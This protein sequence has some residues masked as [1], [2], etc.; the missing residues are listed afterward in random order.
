[1]IRCSRPGNDYVY[2]S[3]IFSF[4]DWVYEAGPHWGL[5]TGEG[6]PHATYYAFR[7][8]IRALQ[9]AKPTFQAAADSPDLLAIATK[10]PDGKI[11][12]L[13]LNWS[14]TVSYNIR[15]DLSGLLSD[16]TGEIRQFS[17][18]VRDEVVGQTTITD[19]VSDFAVPH[20]SVVLVTYDR[21]G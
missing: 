9:G 16:G 18:D 21:V 1:M 8:A 11:N 17:A 3:H 6:K 4:Y 15:A 12:L 14:E 10:D 7:M 5:I 2:G 19:G 13:V 20:Y